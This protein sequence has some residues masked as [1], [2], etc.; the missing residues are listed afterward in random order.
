[1]NNCVSVVVV[2]GVITVQEKAEVSALFLAL[3]YLFIKKNPSNRTLIF[4][5]FRSCLQAHDFL[6]FDND[7][8]VCTF[9]KLELLQRECYILLC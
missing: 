9:N 5:S 6:E 1:M 2:L 7:M 4:T 3:E 8:I